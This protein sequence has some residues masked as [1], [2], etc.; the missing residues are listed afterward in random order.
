MG[1][2]LKVMKYAIFMEERLTLLIKGEEER[3]MP[4]NVKLGEPAVL[5]CTCSSGT[6]KNI[7]ID[8]IEKMGVV[9]DDR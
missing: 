1:E 6:V 8:D 5:E 4:L 9:Q 2:M 7:S 3:V